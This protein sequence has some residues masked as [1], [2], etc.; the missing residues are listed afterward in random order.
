MQAYALCAPGH[1]RGLATDRKQ[2]R[3][4]LRLTLPSSGY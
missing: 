2:M 1:M 4:I 3:E